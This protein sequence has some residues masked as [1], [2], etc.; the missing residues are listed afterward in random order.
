MQKEPANKTRF[1]VE[2]LRSIAA[3]YNIE[4]TSLSYDWIIRLRRNNM[5]H[6]VYGYNFDLN[7]GASILIANDKS[8][9]SAI[10]EQFSIPHVEHTLFLTPNLTEYIGFKGN[11]LRAVRYAEKAGYPIVCKTNQGT[12]GNDV[13]KVSTQ[14]ELEAAF[15]QVHAT[16][17]G[18]TL[19]PYYPIIAEYRI[20]LLNGVELLCYEKKRPHVVGDGRSTFFELL[21]KN[22]SHS[23]EIL[24]AA[25]KNPAF[26][27]HQIPEI[28]N[29][30]PII[31][32]H[33]LGKGAVPVFSISPKIQKNLLELAQKVCAATGLQFASVDIIQTAHGMK[34]MEV[35][36]G[37]ML[38]NLSRVSN[39]GYQLAFHA[40]EHA[41]AAMF[42][43]KADIDKCSQK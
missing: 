11:W 41:I 25:L 18:L 21:K 9:L 42:G 43:L 36:A 5:M 17:R 24:K 19:S 6:Y 23:P 33:N 35:N 22:E 16:A 26:P 27:L 37:I 4:F 7:P 14:T 32:K 31:W 12:G 28:G 13:F 40:Y 30:I 8:A 2:A 3:K 29:E 39:K 38:E 20:I 15:Q 10:L 1:L 34:A